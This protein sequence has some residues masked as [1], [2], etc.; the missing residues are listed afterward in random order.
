MVDN[1]D[2]I[3]D[4]IHFD[5]EDDF[6]HLQIIKRK[7]ENPE[8]GSNSYVLKTY[9]IKSHNELENIKPEVINACQFNNARAYI[10][11]N[12]RS[13]ERTAFMTLKKVTDIIMNKDYKS[14]RNA[15]SSVCGEYGTGR[16]K[17]WIIDVDFDDFIPNLESQNLLELERFISQLQLSARKS[18]VVLE[19]LMTKNGLHLIVSPF[20]L[21]LFKERYP[22]IDIH[23]NNPTI[24]FVP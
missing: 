3:K 20:N 11:L 7:K 19:R 1:F 16:D 12:V 18:N 24:L 22:H 5:S 15:Y 9:Y 10:N 2:K 17:T 23:K 21:Q 13:F 6:Y 14:V 4:L 8:I